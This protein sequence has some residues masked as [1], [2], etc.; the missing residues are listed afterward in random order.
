MKMIEQCEYYFDSE[1]IML[2]Q[3]DDISYKQG[4]MEMIKV[5]E[6][7]QYISMIKTIKNILNKDEMRN[8][9]DNSENNLVFKPHHFSHSGFWTEKSHLRLLLFYDELEVNNPLAETAGVYKIGMFYFTIL[10]LTRKFN[11]DLKNIFLVAIIFSEDIKKYGINRVLERIIIDIKELEINGIQTNNKLYKASIAQCVG[12]NLGIH[13]L[14]NL[15]CCFIGNNICHLCDANTERIQLEFNENAYERKT[16]EIYE[17]NLVQVLSN[18]ENRKVFG[19]NDK[20]MLNELRYFHTSNNYSFDL[21]HDLWEGVVQ[22]ELS[23]ILSRYIF[24]DKIFD[25]EFLNSRIVSF[26]Y[27]VTDSANRPSPLKIDSKKTKKI[28]VNQKAAKI[29][30]LFRYLPFIIGDKIE[31]ENRYW[32]LYTILS[33]IVDILY[34]NNLTLEIIAQLEWL[35]EDHHHLFKQLFNTVTLKKAP[36]HDTLWDCTQKSW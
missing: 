8:L 3:R 1:E 26:K 36:Q 2:G 28:K 7:F 6:T 35:V 33:R 30:C 17:E 10:N 27:G 12:D 9:I 31:Q 32:Q 4:K 21:T 25:F 11:S 15:K 22:I 14:F 20:C 29:K 18:N 23:L 16:K 5:N 34:S 24:V 19:V 13:Q